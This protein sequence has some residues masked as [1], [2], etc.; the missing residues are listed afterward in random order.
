[1]Q[2]QEYINEIKRLMISQYGFKENQG[3]PMNV[4]DGRYPMEIEGKTDYVLI[5]DSKIHCCNFEPPA[6]VPA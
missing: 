6:T 2:M 1:M 4:P 3:V 5:K